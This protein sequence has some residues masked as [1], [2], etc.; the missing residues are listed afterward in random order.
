[1]A[2]PETYGRN[3]QSIADLEQ[4]LYDIFQDHPQCSY[5][6]SD[7]P[8][9]PGDALVDV[10]RT[11]S[12]NHNAAEL[13]TRDEEE[14]LTSLL[15]STPGLQ[16]TPQVLLQFIAM[17]TTMEPRHSPDDSPPPDA[18]PDADQDE[19]GRSEDRDEDGINSRSSSRDSTATYYRSSSRGPQTPQDSVFDSG[20]RQRTTPLKNN[21]PPS[22]WSRRPPPRRRKSDAG[23][24]RASSD[25][26]SGTS[27]PGAFAR[28]PGRSRAPSNPVS[29]TITSPQLAKS[30]SSPPFG[31]T[32]SRPH[33]R[34]QSQPQGHFN[35]FNADNYP[36][37][38][39][40]REHDHRQTGLMS[41]PQ[42]DVSFDDEQPSFHEQL[43]SLQ[44]PRKDSDSDSDSDIDEV[45][46][47]LVMDRS[48]AS[49][50]VSMDME[51]R[52]DALQ[53][54]NT[55]L[56]RKLVEAERTLQN[57]LADHEQEL[58]EMQIRLEEAR[59]ELSATKREEKELRSKERQNSTQIGAL[60]SEVAK[61]QKSLDTAR[62][63]Y[64]SLQ[65]QYLEQCS[66]AE[67]M[68]NSLRRRD[69]EIKDMKEAANLQSLEAQKWMREQAT[70]EERIAILE[71]EIS[72]AQQA[73][74]Q[75]DEQKQENMMLK[76]T[77]DRMRFD[78]DELR[79]SANSEGGTGSGRTSVYGSVSKSLGAELLS[80]MQD[81]KWDMEGDEDEDEESSTE[82]EVD[83]E[84]EDTESEDYVQTIITRTKRVGNHVTWFDQPDNVYCDDLQKVPSRAKRLETLKI[85]ELK[86]YS[87]TGT[88]H[89]SDE[90]TSSSGIQ[91]DP[92]PRIL[93]ASFS[94]QT[95]EAPVSTMFTQTEPEP[96]PIPPPVVITVERE[97]QT[98]EVQ[99]EA[100]TSG[101]TTED[102]DDALAS[103]SST[104]LPPTPKA[105]HDHLLPHGHDLPPAYDKVTGEDLAVRVANETIK[106]WHPGLTLPIG[107]LVGG[108]SEEAIEDWKALKEELGVECTAI[109]KLVEESARSAQPPRSSREKRRKSSRFYN[110]YNT[111]VYGDPDGGSLGSGQLLICLGASALVAFL[112]GQAMAPQYAVPGGATYYDRAAWA[113][114]NSMQAAGEGFS[115]DGSAAVW[116]F[117]G[118]LGGDAAR[119]LRGWP[120]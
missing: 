22:T 63:S 83:P 40:E 84:E 118:R 31:A 48:A 60:E 95:E 4:D 15:A 97:I 11:F 47:G 52:L 23:H 96:E 26:E 94:V 69:Q 19:R 93:T 17:Q 3:R 59:S 108:I 70:Y 13:M 101:Q 119:T 85:D 34:A 39:P 109:D 86:E 72:M 81:A 38:S 114:F 21:A 106:A 1:M 30:M 77:I 12:R 37:S 102:E 46:L 67:R 82:H 79:N 43:N 56:G 91:T 99:P 80:K 53:R 68:R 103:S 62:G 51:Q 5:N 90:F 29:P 9:I 49:S 25:S 2:M 27:A 110:I 33:S 74:E 32:H 104:L 45:F 20:R 54:L 105:K 16:V 113:S 88:Q 14:Q 42:S 111:Y 92:P 100:S 57:R 10:L 66:E 50:T 61:L 73:A 117:L 89:E 7:E 116:S 24:S 112:M 75:L 71:G 55:D 87:D 107:P 41:P 6:D 58:E 35:S 115:G 120:T 44:M 8:V 78:M 65:K 28:T 76:E 98:D 64:Q 18:S 36:G